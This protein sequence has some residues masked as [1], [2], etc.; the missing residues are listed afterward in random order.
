M[1]ILGDSNDDDD[2]NNGDHND[3][4]NGEKTPTNQNKASPISDAFWHVLQRTNEQQ[5]NQPTNQQNL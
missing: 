4:Y 1:M 3:D 2:N 5:T